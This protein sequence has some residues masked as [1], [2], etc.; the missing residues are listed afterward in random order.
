[1]KTDIIFSFDTED[2]TSN[3]AADAIFRQAEIL[4]EEGVRGGFCV[5]GLVAKQLKAWGR[6]DVIQALSHHDILNHSYAHSVHPTINEYTDLEDFDAAYTELRRQEDES[7]DLIRETFEGV[8]VLGA[9]PPGNQKSYV[10][11]YA[12][13]D[14]SLPIYADTVCDT[15]DGRGAYLCNI[16]QTKYTYMMENFM[17]EDDSDEYMKALLDRLATYRRAI[18]FTHPNMAIFKMFWDT[19]NYDKENKCEFGEW[20]FSERRPAEVTERFYDSIRR[21][22][23]MMKNDGRFNITSYSAVA[24]KV[25]AEE[26]R[27]IRKEDLPSIKAQLEKE[28]AP[29]ASPSYSIADIFLACKAMLLGAQE[30]LCGKTCG[31]LDT[32]YAI[33]A[34]ISVSAADMIASAKTLNTDRFLPTEIAVGGQKLGP[35]DW[36]MAALGVLC[37]EE[38]VSLVPQ[39]QL[40]SLDVLPELRDLVLVGDWLQ[41]DS[42]KDEYLSKRLRLQIWTLRFMEE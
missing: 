38:S 6:D 32:P 9:C 12:Y 18:C 22:I 7:M 28:F 16:Y 42:F 8:D 25:R 21:F 10:A 3:E 29:I 2:F 13:A 4:R 17:Y 1:M 20:A 19:I 15:A 36:L 11:M 5:V 34:D 33:K 27:I 39:S 35:A 31:F 41:S 24:E 14:M 40:P 37:G 26:S 23:R 30:H